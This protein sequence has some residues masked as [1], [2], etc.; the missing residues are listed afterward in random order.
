MLEIPDA[1]SGLPALCYESVARPCRDAIA[2]PRRAG[3]AGLRSQG[4]TAQAFN[5][6]I[7][8]PLAAAAPGR[9]RWLVAGAP[10]VAARATAGVSVNGRRSRHERT[11]NREN[12]DDLLEPCHL[13]PSFSLEE[14]E[15][16]QAVTTF[17]RGQSGRP[18]GLTVRNPSLDLCS[19]I[20]ST[21]PQGALH[22][23][24]REVPGRGGTANLDASV[25]RRRRRPLTIDRFRTTLAGAKEGA[26]LDSTRVP[27]KRG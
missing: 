7:P 19:G 13:N 17:M 21:S 27:V 20:T 6:V 14:Q 10:M 18:P 5:C 22:G 2:Q 16:T 3:R 11:Q 4:R 23:G 12:D 8:G 25:Q 9:W 1:R 15:R 24:S 26:S